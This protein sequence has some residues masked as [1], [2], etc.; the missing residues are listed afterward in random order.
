MSK[1]RESNKYYFTKQTEEA[2]I[3]YNK[4]TD[5]YEKNLL[6]NNYIKSAF[7][8]LT[9]VLINDYNFYHVDDTVES[10]Q[11]KTIIHLMEKLK[12]YNPQKGKAF[13]FFTKVAYNFLI[14]ENQRNYNEMKKFIDID[15]RNDLHD[16]E[17]ND[18]EERIQFFEDFILYLEENL[19]DIFSIHKPEFKI[20]SALIEIIK[21]REHLEPFLNN[22]NKKAIYLMI[23]EMTNVQSIQITR[24]VAKL[25]NIFKQVQENYLTTGRIIYIKPPRKKRCKY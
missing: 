5:F 9:E 8:T 16:N 1:T 20:T 23:K 12:N 25:K 6:Y 15:T 7:F 22:Y 13:S 11:N 3:Q 21:R 17:E 18:L 14:G 19:L 10:A 4:S 24:T 2:I